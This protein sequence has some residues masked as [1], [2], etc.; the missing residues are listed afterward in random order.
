MKSRLHTTPYRLI[1]RSVSRGRSNRPSSRTSSYPPTSQRQPPPAPESTHH[2][3]PVHSV[4]ASPNRTHRPGS[5]APSALLSH[6]SSRVPAS[7]P[8]PSRYA[9]ALR[10]IG[11]QDPAGSPSC[12]PRAARAGARACRGLGL[13]SCCMSRVA[14]FV[15]RSSTS[16]IYLTS[17]SGRLRKENR[18]GCLAGG[19]DRDDGLACRRAAPVRG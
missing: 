13:R 10:E 6:K 3:Q 11:G 15:S 14:R 1:T 4:T 8:T 16:S 2:N 17:S 7:L 12:P 18:D 9:R 5:P 19:F